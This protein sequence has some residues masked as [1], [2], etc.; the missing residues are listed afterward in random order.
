MS[1]PKIETVVEPL[2]A[3]PARKRQPKKA[4]AKPVEE[5]VA[6]RRLRISGRTKK[7]R[8][9]AHL[10]RLARKK[11]IAVCIEVFDRLRPNLVKLSL[12]SSQD[13]FE[14]MAMALEAL[15]RDLRRLGEDAE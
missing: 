9:D 10:P 6:R 5:P 8:A 2:P 13:R 15:G 14:S 11:E 4:V 12:G 3:K 7:I 1:D